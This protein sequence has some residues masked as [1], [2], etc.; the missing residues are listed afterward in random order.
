VLQCQGGTALVFTAYYLIAAEQADEK[1][2]RV[3]A[4]LTLEHLRV[5]CRN[6]ATHSLDRCKQTAP[7]E[8]YELLEPGI[9]SFAAVA[10]RDI[11]S[12][13][14]TA[15]YLIAA[16]QADEKVRRVRA[17]LTLFIA[18]QNPASK[19]VVIHVARKKDREYMFA[20][21]SGHSR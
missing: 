17:T 15:Y 9:E 19:P 6:T 18:V 21:G 11:A 4:T 12:L 16:E 3:R 13:V 5:S 1:V 7:G 10:L 20:N 8:E 2:R 14:F